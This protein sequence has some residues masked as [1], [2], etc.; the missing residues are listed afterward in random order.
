MRIG[1]LNKRVVLQRA[2]SVAD[3]MGGTTDTWTDQSEVWAAI[4]PTSASELVAA[5]ATTMV[6][7]HRVRIR[8]RDDI[9][10]T[11]RVRYGERY[12]AIV[13]VVNPN[14]NGVILDLLCK[15]AAT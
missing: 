9:R 4:W 13:S 15:E 5:N 14:E 11:W 2:T 1:D 10:P 8:Y 6:I 7:T 3:G 12:F